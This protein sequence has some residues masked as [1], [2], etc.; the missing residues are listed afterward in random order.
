[1]FVWAFNT[2]DAVLL[3]WCSILKNDN[4]YTLLNVF[5]IMVGVVGVFRAS[6]LSFPELNTAW[7]HFLAQCSALFS[8]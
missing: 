8:Q 4:A 1:M 2:T 3:S 5:W 7:L 6:A